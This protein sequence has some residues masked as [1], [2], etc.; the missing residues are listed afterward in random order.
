V[1]FGSL[2]K[3]EAFPMLPASL[4][5]GHVGEFVGELES[6]HFFMRL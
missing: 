4:L 6:G 5:S 3:A 1:P 2:E